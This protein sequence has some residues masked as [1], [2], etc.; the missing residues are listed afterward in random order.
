MTSEYR[1]LSK[2][3]LCPSVTAKGE[4]EIIVVGTLLTTV[5]ES[6]LKRATGQNIAPY[7]RVVRIPRE[8]FEAAV[9][10]I[11]GEKVEA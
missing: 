2:G 8:V 9:D 7:E 1:L 5:E 6:A 10:K 11:L 3:P 4:N